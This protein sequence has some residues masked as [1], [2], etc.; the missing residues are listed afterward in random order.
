ML[1][2]GVRQAISQ[3][4]FLSSPSIIVG[5]DRKRKRNPLNLKQSGTPQKKFS[6]NRKCFDYFSR[7]AIDLPKKT[8]K[9]KAD[10]VF[11]TMT[12]PL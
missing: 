12:F 11:R 2:Q 4:G 7:L 9:D 5:L 6:L 8:I 1:F 10:Q 3:C